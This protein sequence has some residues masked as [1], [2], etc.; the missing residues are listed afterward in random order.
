[1]ILRVYGN[2]DMHR[3]T[4]Y[5]IDWGSMS[6]VGNTSLNSIPAIVDR[7]N[8]EIYNDSVISFKKTT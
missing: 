8:I 5:S 2:F 1:M 4:E 3:L 7:L 6:V